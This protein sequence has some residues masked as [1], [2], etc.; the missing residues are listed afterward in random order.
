M[1]FPVEIKFAGV[2]TT[3]GG[4]GLVSLCNASDVQVK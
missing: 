1:G 3:V 4:T 2:Y